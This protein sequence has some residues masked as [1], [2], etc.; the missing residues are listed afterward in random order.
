MRAGMVVEVR[1]GMVV[2]VMAC[3][4][5][6]A[7]VWCVEVEVLFEEVEPFS[8]PLLVMKWAWF[9]GSRQG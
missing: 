6:V 3:F 8:Y 9:Q 7:L 1:A 4:E 5:A 2:E